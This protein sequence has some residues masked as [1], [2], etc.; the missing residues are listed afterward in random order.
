MNLASRIEGVTKKYGVKILISEFTR[1]EIDPTF[2][3]REVDSIKV[4]GKSTPVKIFELLGACKE[5][6]DDAKLWRKY[7]ISYRSFISHDAHHPHHMIDQ[8]QRYRYTSLPSYV[9]LIGI[10]FSYASLRGRTSTI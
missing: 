6:V 2:I 3:T 4:L 5:E 8:S 7:S 10:L 1:K 9:S